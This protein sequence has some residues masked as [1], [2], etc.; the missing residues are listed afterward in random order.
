MNIEKGCFIKEV[1]FLFWFL[2]LLF[3]PIECNLIMHFFPPFVFFFSSVFFI[4][5]SQTLDF[6]RQPDLCL[7]RLLIIT[8]GG[9]VLWLFLA[10]CHL[11]VKLDEN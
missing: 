4:T 3:F 5:S 9:G 6:L 10:V 1:S 7:D 2:F 8:A 11:T